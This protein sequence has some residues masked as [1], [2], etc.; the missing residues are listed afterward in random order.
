MLS[1]EDGVREG[2]EREVVK[3]WPGRSPTH[4]AFLSTLTCCCCFAR[5]PTP[6]PPFQL[7]RMRF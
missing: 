4:L 1:E 6:T 7:S 2:A 5:T 3:R